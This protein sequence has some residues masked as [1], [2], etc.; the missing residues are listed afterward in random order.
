MKLFP[1]IRVWEQNWTICTV[2]PILLPS[3]GSEFFLNL[4]DK[5]MINHHQNIKCLFISK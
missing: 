2:L 3:V 5:G 4:T 1:V